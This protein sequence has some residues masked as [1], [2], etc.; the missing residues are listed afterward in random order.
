MGNG[1]EGVSDFKLSLDW[2]KHVC[3]SSWCFFSNPSIHFTEITLFWMYLPRKLDYDLKWQEEHFISTDVSVAYIIR[4]TTNV[5][6]GFGEMQINRRRWTGYQMHRGR[7]DP[8][9]GK[10]CRS[11]SHGVARDVKELLNW[12]TSTGISGVFAPFVM[13]A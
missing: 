5:W 6:W 13:M 12:C 9:R 2:D 10:F 4:D 7:D 1:G 3:L 11:R 8:I